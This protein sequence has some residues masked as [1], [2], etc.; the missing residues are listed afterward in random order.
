MPG[1]AVTETPASETTICT[2]YEKCGTKRRCI[3]A[4]VKEERKKR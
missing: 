2:I 1:D 4:E 3:E